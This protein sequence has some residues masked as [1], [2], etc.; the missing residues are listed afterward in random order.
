[1][2][3]VG[4]NT[5]CCEH[6]QSLSDLFGSIIST[7]SEMDRQIT[8]IELDSRCVGEGDLFVAMPGDVVDGRNYI[9]QAINQGAAA[10][11]YESS[12]YEGCVAEILDDE[13]VMLPVE[14]LRA[15]VSEIAAR[16]FDHPSKKMKMIGVTG[17]N[18]KTTFSYL[19]AQAW[20]L[21][22][23]KSGMMG[24]IGNGYP[25][26]LQKS[27]LTTDNAIAIQGR[28]AS[29]VCEQAETV[30]MEVSSHGLSQ[31]RVS[32]VEFDIAVFTNLSQDHLDYHLTL[33]KY[34]EEKAKLFAFPH[35]NLAVINAD[36]EFGQ[37]LLQ[38]NTAKNSI[39][40]GLSIADISPINL[41][42]DHQG[43][44]FDVAWKGK[45]VQIRS[46]LIGLINVP[47]LLA[48]IACLVG[49]EVGLE[50]IG[51]AIKK[52]KP[53]PGRMEVFVSAAKN[54]STAKVVVDYAHTP[55]ALKRALS[56]LKHISDGE[57]MVVF[58]CGGD[59]DKGKRAQM[60]RVAEQFAD[61][62]IVT[63]DN[64]RTESPQAIAEEILSGMEVPSRVVHCR[65]KAIE[66]AMSCCDPNGFVLIAG[67]GHEDYQLTNDG[68]TELSD[69]DI[70]K[71]AL[72]R[73]E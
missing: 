27:A 33:E 58:G 35:L 26:K 43:I 55:D 16:F 52:L 37:V 21:L 34:G 72:E 45:M 53:P 64:P 54:N 23:Q 4:T 29:F 32:G 42:V 5:V 66:I 15:N 73:M 24:T 61:Q 17:T 49:C 56:S 12:G 9:A 41:C 39:S 28:L 36:D 13:V 38:E 1:M 40:Y 19:M 60:G 65:K 44:K 62:V 69:R 20:E 18:G 22:G 68:V 25:M 67:K 59:R 71:R 50:E 31:D 7:D 2:S 8:G 63:D 11:S 51:N 47:N 70:V 3:M 30:C 10:V 14:N 6:S 46:S 48:V 57:V